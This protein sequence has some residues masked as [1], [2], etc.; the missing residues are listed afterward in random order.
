MNLPLRVAT[1]NSLRNN[2]ISNSNGNMTNTQ[3]IFIL[4][5]F[6]LIILSLLYLG[7]KYHKE[8]NKHLGVDTYKTRR[9]LK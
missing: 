4:I 9:K 6:I 1:Q 2:F 3:C 8:L 5:I 7:I